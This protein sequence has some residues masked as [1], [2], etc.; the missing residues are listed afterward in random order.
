[1]CPVVIRTGGAGT[2]GNQGPPG[3][4]GPNGPDGFVPTDYAN[5]IRMG[6]PVLL[7]AQVP[8]TAVQNASS[9]DW[10]VIGGS[11][12]VG[13]SGTYWVDYE[14]LVNNVSGVEVESIL[15]ITPGTYV[16]GTHMVSFYNAFPNGV[17]PVIIAPFPYI[18]NRLSGSTIVPLQKGDLI[19]IAVQATQGSIIDSTPDLD[20]A[21]IRFRRFV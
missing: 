18:I 21:S 8:L 3:S 15:Q 14:L 4:N 2:P 17:P 20:V 5:F 7:P 10:Q 16:S 6:P 12:L 1:M 11:A 13:A 9:A 19:T